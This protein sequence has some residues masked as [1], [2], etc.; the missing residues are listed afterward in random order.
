MGRQAAWREERGEQTVVWVE[1]MLLGFASA[2]A[3]QKLYLSLTFFSLPDLTPVLR[4]RLCRWDGM[5]F[6]CP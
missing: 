5:C 1:G 6:L 4:G 2:K 3:W